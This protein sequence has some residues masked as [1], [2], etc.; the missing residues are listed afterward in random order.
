M[1][2]HLRELA[3]APAEIFTPEDIVFTSKKYKYIYRKG[4]F[5]TSTQM[6]NDRVFTS[7]PPG[8]IFTSEPV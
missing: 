6:L 5:M 3:G 1:E 8:L 7:R 4:H 2:D